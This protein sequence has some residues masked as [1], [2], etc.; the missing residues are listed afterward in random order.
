MTKKLGCQIKKVKT[1]IIGRQL[2]HH[3]LTELIKN[4]EEKNWS[5]IRYKTEK[6]DHRKAVFSSS[7]TRPNQKVYESSYIIIY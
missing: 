5:I 4:F 1:L 3:T 6:I 2:F 7:I